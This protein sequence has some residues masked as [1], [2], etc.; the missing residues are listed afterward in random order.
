MIF[1]GTFLGYTEWSKTRLQGKLF[2]IDPLQK[3][4]SIVVFNITI[5]VRTTHQKNIIYN[6]YI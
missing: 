2:L 3:G 1:I 5:N 6:L 4:Y